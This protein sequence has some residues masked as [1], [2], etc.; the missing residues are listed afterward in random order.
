MNTF[1]NTLPTIKSGHT[2]AVGHLTHQN[3]MN[4][5]EPAPINI[6]TL[7]DIDKILEDIKQQSAVVAKPIEPIFF[8]YLNLS[9]EQHEQISNKENDDVNEAGNGDELNNGP[10]ELAGMILYEFIFF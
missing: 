8:I 9:I 1:H 3:S 7:Y 5:Y 4:V 10:D 6:K 2:T